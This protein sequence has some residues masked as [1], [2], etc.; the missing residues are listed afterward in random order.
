MFAMLPVITVLIKIPAL[1]AV[2]LSLKSAGPALLALVLAML[3]AF[4]ALAV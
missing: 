4:T 3:T 2:L 1:G